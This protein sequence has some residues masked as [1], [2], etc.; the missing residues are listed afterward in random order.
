MKTKILSLIL[1]VIALVSPA[2]AQYAVTV[3]ADPIE[4]ADHIQDL[5]QWATSIQDLETQINQLNQY[6]QIGQT[7][8]SYVGNPASAA[9]AM[10]LQLLGATGL[11]QSVGQLTTALNQTVDGAKALENSGSQLYGA[12]ANQTPG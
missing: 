7:V 9:Q 12:V 10:E 8:E 1:L 3:V 11:T 6:I 5:A 2:R 4:S